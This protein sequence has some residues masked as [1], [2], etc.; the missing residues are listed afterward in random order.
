MRF[1]IQP[2]HGGGRSE[3][4]YIFRHTAVAF[5]SAKSVNE[6]TEA[7]GMIQRDESFISICGHFRIVDDFIVLLRVFSWYRIATLFANSW[8]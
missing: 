6:E 3:Q 1:D 7:L 8:I 4:M 2:P 5:I